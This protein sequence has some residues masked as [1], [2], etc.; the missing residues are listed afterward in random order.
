FCVLVGRSADNS[1]LPSSPAVSRSDPRSSIFLAQPL[2]PAKDFLFGDK[3][4]VGDA[5]NSEP[6]ERPLVGIDAGQTQAFL[7]RDPVGAG[8]VGDE[9]SMSVLPR[10]LE[11]SSAVQSAPAMPPLP[12]P[13]TLGV[14]ETE[15]AEVPRVRREI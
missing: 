13:M 3:N 15:V 1:S 9:P 7:S 10:R 11:L 6:G 2:P 14:G 5:A 12:P 8:Q 4:G